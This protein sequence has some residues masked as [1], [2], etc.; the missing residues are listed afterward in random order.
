MDDNRRTNRRR[1][2]KG[3]TIEFDRCAYSCAVRNLSEVGAALDVPFA[4][5]I[6]HEFKL[7]IERDQIIRHCRAIWRKVN[8]LGVEFGQVGGPQL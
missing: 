6:P 4:V 1:V 8:R 2:L 3:A 5:T 7:T